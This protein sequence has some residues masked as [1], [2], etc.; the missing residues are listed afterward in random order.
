[1]IDLLLTLPE[2][3]EAMARRGKAPQQESRAGHFLHHLNRHG[4]CTTF[5]KGCSGGSRIHHLP[6]HHR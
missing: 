1:M 4:D 5:E 3:H 6:R 2:M